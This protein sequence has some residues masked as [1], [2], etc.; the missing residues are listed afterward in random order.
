MTLEE[1]VDG[2]AEGTADQDEDEDEEIDAPGTE[3]LVHRV[4]TRMLIFLLAAHEE[5]GV[6]DDGHDGSHR[7]DDGW[8]L[9]SQIAGAD[10]LHSDADQSDPEGER[11]VLA[12]SLLVGQPQDDEGQQ[13]E[14]RRQLDHG[15]GRDLA[16]GLGR[17]RTARRH[18]VAQR[19]HRH[20][21]SSEASSHGV[22]DEGHQ[23]REHRLEAQADEDGSRDGHGRAEAGHALKQ[24]AEAPDEHQDQ[25]AAVVGERGELLLDDLNLLRLHQNVIAVDGHQYNNKDREDGLQGS[26]DERPAHHAGN[27][28]L[29]QLLRQHVQRRRHQKGQQGGDDERDE[30][31]LVAGHLQ[32]QHQYEEQQDRNNGN[33]DGHRFR[34]LGCYS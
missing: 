6:D 15:E 12:P 34:V 33:N 25:H 3:G 17:S 23:S 29:S 22:A 21:D 8:R 5:L 26:F 13:H 9:G 11:D 4:V 20:A 1:L 28:R 14:Q 16:D 7:P 30:R 32:P 24:S 2:R 10:I 19:R 18:L 31:T 27:R